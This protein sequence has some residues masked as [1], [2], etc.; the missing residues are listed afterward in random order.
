MSAGIVLQQM[1]MI[2]LLI[3]SGYVLSRRNMLPEGTSKGLSAMVVNV[4]NPALLIVSAF[5]R[6]PSVTNGKVLTAAKA[7]LLLY[8]VLIAAGLVLPRLLAI[9]K[10]QRS[11]YNM[12]C[13]FGNTGFIGIPVIAAVVGSQALIYVAIINVFFNL[14]IYTYGIALVD[15]EKKTSF[16]W[17]RL[18]NMGTIASVVT[19]LVFLLQPSVPELIPETLNYMGQATTFLAM[20][21]IGISLS[22]MPVRRLLGDWKMY[23]F[24]AIRFVAIPIALTFVFRL[25][26]TDEDLYHTMV[27]LSAVPVANFPLMMAEEMG[28]DGEVFSRGIILSTLLSLITIPVV[29]AFV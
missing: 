25:F 24:L 9:E 8:V 16:Q 21:V 17:R 12:M 6:D 26:V 1:M 27:L 11:H 19:I 13:L 15:T 10:K 14:L 18:I 7:G 28:V 3:L 20:V 23:V 4:C 29:A 2:F 5:D 22:K